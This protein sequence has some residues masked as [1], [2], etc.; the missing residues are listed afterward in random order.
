MRSLFSVF[1]A[2][3][4]LGSGAFAQTTPCV[5]LACQQMLCP[6]GSTTSVSGIVYAPN[7]TDPLPNVQVY[8][9]NASVAAF[10]PG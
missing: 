10:T 8:V 6:A 4:S 1:A 7:G 2:A 3:L 9:P 5:G